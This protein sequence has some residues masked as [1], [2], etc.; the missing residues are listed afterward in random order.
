MEELLVNKLIE[1]IVKLQEQI[2]NVDDENRIPN[3]LEWDYGTNE[4]LTDDNKIKTLR[5]IQQT[6]AIPYETR[7][8]IITPIINKLLD[9]PITDMDL[10]K[11]NEEE[12][13]KL[14]FEYEEI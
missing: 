11:G 2:N 4:K 9:E 7:A 1:N 10:S 14:K 3:D 5:A 12:R 8:K 13:E 6:M